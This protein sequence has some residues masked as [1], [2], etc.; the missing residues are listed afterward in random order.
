MDA[1]VPMTREVT[2]VPPGLSLSVAYTVM[3]RKRVRHLPVLHAGKLL[4]ILSDRD[5]LV[6]ATLRPD[7]SLQEPDGPVA[8]A[9]TPAPIL[10]EPETPVAELARIMTERKIDAVPV[11]SGS[12][13]VGLVTTTDL[14]FLLVGGH[15]ARRPLPFEFR[16][17]EEQAS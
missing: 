6:R 15:E 12:R 3:E 14:L 10:C 2:V 8:L 1:S 5:V 13:M 17:V 4:G 9:M 11:V 16:V 7:G